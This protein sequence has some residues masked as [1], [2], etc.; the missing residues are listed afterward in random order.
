MRTFPF[1]QIVFVEFFR[2]F[3]RH[4]EAGAPAVRKRILDDPALFAVDESAAGTLEQTLA[5][6]RMAPDMP[7]PGF[8]DFLNGL[9]FREGF[10]WRPGS[11]SSFKKLCI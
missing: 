7:T 11:W 8:L 4:A 3:M 9:H 6:S 5:H 1:G 2:P 10:C